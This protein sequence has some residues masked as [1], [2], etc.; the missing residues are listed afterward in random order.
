MA[1]IE[2]LKERGVL[3]GVAHEGLIGI[4][5]FPNRRIYLTKRCEDWLANSL[6]LLAAENDAVL[7]PELQ[8]LARFRQFIR[9]DPLNFPTQLN[10]LTHASGIIW[11]LKTAD[12]RL[13]GGF[14]LVDCFVADRCLTKKQLLGPPNLYNGVA[15]EVEHALNAL[16][17]DPPKFI[18]GR[19]LRNVISS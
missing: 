15:G 17:L 2:M 1:T 14:H 10:F 5:E 18:Q 3:V 16:E 12:I 6:P 11:E 8:L 7:S 13:F 9:G 19:D 4:R